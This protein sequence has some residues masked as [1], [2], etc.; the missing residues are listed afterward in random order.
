M[1]YFSFRCFILVSNVKNK[2]RH[3]RMKIKRLFSQKLKMGF[4]RASMHAQR[5]AVGSRSQ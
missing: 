1:S 4:Y 5:R 3:S 2:L